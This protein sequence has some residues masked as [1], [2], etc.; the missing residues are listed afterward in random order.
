MLKR[1]AGTIL[2]PFRAGE[3]KLIWNNPAFANIPATIH[4]SSPAFKAEEKIP[5]RHAGRGVGDNISPPLTINNL[6][7]LTKSLVVF[8]EDPD[9]PLPRP[10]L[11]FIAFNLPPEQTDIAEGAFNGD[12]NNLGIASFG[13]I[14]Y[15]GPRALPGHGPH[16]YS[17]AVFALDTTLHF[18]SR[19][20]AA[21]V[22]AALK[23]HVIARGRL[24]GL[25]GED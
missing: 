19:P 2:K 10:V 11:H 14:G 8:L 18:N 6:P 17:F 25:F 21:A 20:K 7:M 1:L 4:L 23:G 24:I 12:G 15:A 13:R 5:L 9:A 3:S 16:H 22:V